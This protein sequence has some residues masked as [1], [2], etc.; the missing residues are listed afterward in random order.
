MQ[1]KK[2]EAQWRF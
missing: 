1:T 2:E